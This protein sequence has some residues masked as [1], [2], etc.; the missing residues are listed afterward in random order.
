MAE[1]VPPGAIPEDQFVSNLGTQPLP[2]GAIPEDQFQMTEDAGSGLGI[3]KTALEQGLSGLT[4]GASKAIETQGIPALAIPP[5][6][7]P[8]AV[9]A[10]QKENPIT[11]FASNLVG[12][13]ALIAGTG[14]LGGVARAVTGAKALGTAASI[15]INALEGAG[16][17]GV[18]QATDDWSQN[19][20]LDAQKI[21]ASAGLGAL[22]GGAV[23]GVIEGIKYKFGTPLAKVSEVGNVAS[24]VPE[25]TEPPVISQVD[26][27]G[28]KNGEFVPS[29]ENSA[30]INQDDVPKIL[31]GLKDQKPDAE[32]IVNAAGEIGAPVL[33]G[34][35]SDS[36]WVQKAEDALINGAPTFSGIK[37]QKLYQQVF[38]AVKNTTDAAVGE[39]SPYTQA[40][41]GSKL[42]ESI[43]QKIAA[44]VEPI[45]K[46]YGA[47]KPYYSEIPLS[48][49][50]APTVAKN[51]SELQEL[52][53]SPSSPEGQLAKR[54][55]N[56]IGNLK[57]VDDVKVYKTILN[58]S[59]S[60]TASTGE[61]RMAGVISDQLSNLESNSI[62][63]FAKNVQAPALKENL[64]GLLA[65]R[66]AA[67]T[68]YKPFKQDLNTLAE[69]L[70]KRKVYG[71]QDAI[72]FIQDLTP[73]SLVKKLFSKNDSGFVQFFSKKFPQEM[74]LMRQYQKGVI[75]DAASK[76]GEFSPTTVFRE[77]N[78]LEP[79]IA[80]SIFSKEELQKIRAAQIVHKSIPKSFNPSG[81]DHT[82][83]FRAFFEHTT[84]ALV[85]NARDFAIS[86]FI[87]SGGGNILSKTSQALKNQVTSSDSKLN[88]G[89]EALFS[90]GSRDRKK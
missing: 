71:A 55:L 11:S 30:A 12:T 17:G 59:I 67:D 82:N 45:N 26:A 37:R 85:S 13:G 39:G 15:G 20:P 22:L 65:Q 50:A 75:R 4:L 44:E 38:D 27:Q 3:A 19:K 24:S 8:E 89:I 32:Q 14:G 7:S 47:L 1:Q 61:K 10:R 66:E 76:T 28:Y 60:P 58:R 54:A 31:E 29:V 88:N 34:M 63:D 57:T 84:G 35:T 80:K 9:A 21:A 72:N 40:E 69:H 87:K 42:A 41:L 43:T 36:K 77:I 79:E 73:E 74:E 56:E 48:E 70:G 16:I 51:L 64:N 33:D 2:P 81:T 86:Q 46:L 49:S 5:I 62:V 83:A 78:K 53:I 68:A 18:N 52:R 25:G 23:G 90:E 6:S